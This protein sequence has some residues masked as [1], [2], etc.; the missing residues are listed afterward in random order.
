MK[1]AIMGYS[2][3]GKSTL[4]RA[5]AQ[6]FGTP[7]FHFDAVQF[8]PGWRIRDEKEKREM[9]EKFMDENESWVIDGNYSK[10]C[11]ERR[12]SEADEI[13]LLLFNRLDCLCRAYR[14]YR[15]YKNTTRPDMAEGCNEKFDL[16]FVGWILWGGRSKRAKKRYRDVILQ[17]GEKTTVIKNQKELNRYLEKLGNVKKNTEEK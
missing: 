11:Y 3:S 2:G 5:L 13:I 17:Y 1:I 7:V 8:L 6:S 15:K 4:A 9:T 14:R 10:L 16:E 12:L